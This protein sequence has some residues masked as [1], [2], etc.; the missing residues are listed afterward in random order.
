MAV[1]SAWLFDPDCA[2]N[3]RTEIMKRFESN[4]EKLFNT[5]H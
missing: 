1:T 3:K 2:F 5:L 4:S